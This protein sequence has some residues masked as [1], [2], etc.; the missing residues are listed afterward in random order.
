MQKYSAFLIQ[1]KGDTMLSRF[2]YTYKTDG[3]ITRSLYTD[4]NLFQGQ[5]GVGEYFFAPDDLTDPNNLLPDDTVLINFL[6]PDGQTTTLRMDYQSEN[7]YWYKVSNG[8]ETDVDITASADLTI[9]FLGIRYST[10]SA[11]LFAKKLPTINANITITPSVQYSPLGLSSGAEDEIL[12][13]LAE[14]E[15]AIAANAADILKN[16][17]NTGYYICDTAGDASNKIVVAPNFNPDNNA[18]ILIKFA[19]VNTA[20]PVFIIVNGHSYTA[21][22]T[23]WKANEVTEWYQDHSAFHGKKYDPTADIAANA[24]DIAAK[25]EKKPDGSNLLIDEFT[26]KIGFVYMPT[27]NEIVVS[28]GSSKTINEAIGEK[29]PTSTL[30]GKS[31]DLAYVAATGVL[32][33]TLFDQSHNLLSVDTVDL[34]LEL[35]IE[36]GSVKTCT[37]DNVPVE[38]YVVGDKYIDL[39]LAN[40]SH[41]YVLVTDLIDQITI[42]ETGS[43]NAVTDI[44]INGTVLTEEKGKTFVE[45]SRTVNGHALSAN[46]TVTKSDVGL[47]NVTN[48]GSVYGGTLIDNWNTLTLCGAY[49]SYTGATGLSAEMNALGVSFHGYHINSNVGTGGA[50][51]R[52][53]AFINTDIVCYERAKVA[54]TWGSWINTTLSKKAG[55][56]DNN[57]FTGTMTILAPTE[58]MHAATRKFVLDSAASGA[59]VLLKT[60][61]LTEDVSSINLLVSGDAVT[62]NKFSI[63]IKFPIEATPQTN[64]SCAL[65]IGTLTIFNDQIGN[66]YTT[67]S[68]ATYKFFKIDIGAKLIHVGYSGN[69][70]SGNIN[71]VTADMPKT[72]FRADSSTIYNTVKV[73]TINF[74]NFIARAETVIYVQKDV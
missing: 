45:T 24:A 28:E 19:N 54:G 70:S 44:S 32:A 33:I 25:L 17:A 38:G 51:Q 69:T 4:D 73:L 39:V 22:Y 14:H 12:S 43:G 71:D 31:I 60:I 64:G 7:G 26:G 74:T 55:L 5:V 18:R 53:I 34:P 8:W 36:S 42:E 62:A 15:V 11:T 40:E 3:T 52:L 65:K 35:L 41:I 10:V 68:Y 37:V 29:L 20:I 27:A 67:T 57:T 23:G 61:T 47:G 46:V 58:D 48:P 2:Y 6:R 50:Y 66:L 1:K 16:A 72:A 9:S 63:V 13:T 30:Y 21:D 49:T 59:S 56:A